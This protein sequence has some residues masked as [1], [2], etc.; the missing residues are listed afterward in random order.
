MNRILIIL[1]FLQTVVFTSIA[2]NRYWVGASGGNW[3]TAANWSLTNGGAG[4]AGAPTSVQDAVINTSVSINID[5]NVGVNSIL[6]TNNSTVVFQTGVTRTIAPTSTSLVNKAFRL[7][8]GSTVTLNCT[9][10][11]GTNNFLLDLSNGFGVTAQIDGTLIFSGTGGS[12]SSNA[13]FSTF[14]GA[15]AFGN[16]IV[17][18]TGY[19]RFLANTG[20]ATTS[21]TSFTMQNGATYEIAKNGGS[22]P[23]GVWQANSL[24]LASGTGAVGPLF[25]G[26]TYGNLQINC[27]GITT[28]IYFNANISFNNVDIV[29]TGADVLRAKTGTTA[30]T[31]TTTI[32]GNLTVSASS[33]LETSG[34]T[35][36]SGNPGIIIVKGNVTNNGTI[37]ENSTVT[38]NQFI[39]QGTSNQNISGTGSYTGD[40]FDF[41]LNNNAGAT[42][43]AAVTL[44]YRYTISAGN[45]TLDN[46]DFTTPDVIQLGAASSTANHIVTNGT[47]KLI[48][49]NVGAI[50]VIFPI[51]AST[52]TYNPV[53]LQN[54]GGL[55]YGLRVEV[56][57]NPP[58]AVPLSAVNR[59]WFISSGVPPGTVDITFN[60]VA[61]DCNAN[62]MPPP[63]NLELGQY[64]GV[65]NIV[66][67]GL[68]QLPLYQV[69]T[70]VNTFGTNTEAPLVLANLGA[71]LAIDKPVSVNYFTGIKQD[72]KH[73]LKWKLTCNSTPAVT[74]FLERST[75]GID[76]VTIF[77]EQATALRC[78]QPSEYNDV[79]PVDGVNYYR[80]KMLDADGK[81]SLSTVVPLI[82]ANTGIYVLNIAPNPITGNSFNVKI[83]AA[84]QQ[85]G[86]IFINDLTGRAI[87]HYVV[88]VT[89]GFNL[90]PVNVATLPNGM[91]QLCLKTQ[92]GKTEVI[93]FVVQK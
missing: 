73:V 84:K 50:T 89:A 40:D 38:G 45:L 67:T 13:R 52:T 65:W 35:T 59:T 78:Q 10:A 51:G 36:T 63:A 46:F 1:L 82:N 30:T 75:N 61:A 22:F 33:I 87:Q 21:A 60:Y 49:Q 74:M 56:G 90:V 29:S 19:I 80:I 64:I 2:Q 72:S 25:L 24:A 23:T 31:Y 69:A 15:L 54:G 86:E 34:N 93:K 17:S 44:P 14:T 48:I 76:Y 41:I 27:P 85:A 26:T 11:S 9:N 37:R 39:L 58:I 20:N 16:V 18:S 5:V 32:N 57:I 12:I 3:S 7:D 88:H 71:I 47:G 79:Q 62:W 42:L 77:S 92:G 81:I 6:I 28:P 91:Y 53:K 70:T 66:Q 4:G 83:S 8:A 43:L 68:T 55:N